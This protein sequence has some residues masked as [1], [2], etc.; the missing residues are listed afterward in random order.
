MSKF[1]TTVSRRDF[2]K[3]LGLA[4]AGLGAAA[5]TTPVFHD[6]DEV[7]ASP[8]SVAKRSWY[9]K[10]REF[11]DPT[12]EYDWSQM[13]RFPE[14]N[15]LRGSHKVEYLTTYISAE[16]Q[17]QRS[18][19][20]TERWQQLLVSNTPGY[21]LRD[22]ALKDGDRKGR[23]GRS[24][25]GPQSA[26]TPEDR[27]VPRWQG[28]P[29]EAGRMLR[30][31]MRIFGAMT[32][33]YVELEANTTRKLIYS[34][35]PKNKHIIKFEDVDQAYETSGPDAKHVIPNKA[36]YSVIF[37]DPDS[38]EFTQRDPAPC[39]YQFHYNWATGIQERTQEFLRGLGYQG[40]GEASTNALGIKPA[41]AT[42]AGLAEMGRHNR[43]NTPE[44]GPLIGLFQVITDLPLAP[45]KPI[46][47]GLFRFCKTC[48]KCADACGEEAIS[49]ETDPSWDIKGP[50][51]NPGHRAYFEDSRKCT[52]WRMLPETCTGS[53][54]QCI[55]Q[56]TF[57]K[58]PM[59]GIHDLVAGTLA[60][61][62]L[63]NGFLRYMDDF[64]DYGVK[65]PAT[66]W[67]T[68]APIYGA[69]ATLGI[70]YL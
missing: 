2:M 37:S 61:T 47:A 24:Y 44:Y 55:A 6:L 59:A 45:N 63:F 13:Q 67:D 28:T 4:G 36:K 54:S 40:I 39:G 35:E 25:L 48:K 5:A 53:A 38:I 57:S 60:V 30:H 58:H 12:M 50:W 42:M 19:H 41:L 26:K 70:D 32:I 10:E 22:W 7:I 1:H 23:V 20:R 15:T 56:C 49:F 62:P 33:G 69:D 64:M 16:E 18:A 17:A 51:Q 11:N 68:P 9:V 52:A 66:F 21:S 8:T 43:N 29:E 27:G 65:D 3:G 14:N 34:H 31:A 46:D